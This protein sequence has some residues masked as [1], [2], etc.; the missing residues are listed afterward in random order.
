MKANYILKWTLV[1]WG[2]SKLSETVKNEKVSRVEE[3]ISEQDD[4]R[5]SGQGQ[6]NKQGEMQDDWLNASCTKVR[7]HSHSN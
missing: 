3:K 6:Q 2:Y 1:K 7:T 4:I 5:A